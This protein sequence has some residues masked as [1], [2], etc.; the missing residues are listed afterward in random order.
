[1]IPEIWDSTKHVFYEGN[2]LCLHNT[3][4]SLAQKSFSFEDDCKKIELLTIDISPTTL[5]YTMTIIPQTDFTNFGQDNV[6]CLVLVDTAQDILKLYQPA[7]I[8]SL[9]AAA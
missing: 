1:M 5:L 4:S 7:E 9:I 6:K 8:T 3:D 2:P